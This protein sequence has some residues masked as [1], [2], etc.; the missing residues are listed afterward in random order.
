M[1]FPTVQFAVFFAVVLPLSWALMGRQRVWKPF[2]LGASYVFY[3]AVDWRFAFLLAG[4]TVVNQGAAM[5][6]VRSGGRGRKAALVGAVGADVAS[7]AVFKY[8]DFFAASVNGAVGLSLPLLHLALP[9]GVSFYTFQ[10]VSYVVDVYR[11]KTALAAPLDYAIYSAFFAHLVAGPIV[12]ATEFIPQLAGPRDAGRVPAGRAFGL[13]AGG[14]VK[15]VAIADLLGVKLVEP[16]FGAPG[17]HSGGEALAAIYGYAVQIYCDFSGYTDMAIGIALLL[18]F[19]FPANFDR[20]YTAT[21]LQDFWRRWHMTLSRWLRDYLYIALGGNRRGRLRLYRNL[22]LTML[23]GGLWHGEL[24]TFVVW[25]GLHGVGLVA[26]R[27]WRDSGL[28]A[29]AA[30][31]VER[32]PAALRRVVS[33]VVTFHVVCLAWVFFRAPDVGTAFA[34]LGRL[35]TLGDG[36]P[37]PSVTP[38]VVTVIAVGLGAQFVPRGMGPWLRGAFGRMPVAAQGVAL[39]CLV[40]V[41][42]AAAGGRGV[43]PF[44]Y[45]RF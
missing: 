23:L 17:A 25:G 37:S 16:V 21:S 26:E 40:T 32:V 15:K 45:F 44:I 36:V 38:L 7:L 31:T 12:R 27:G 30:P 34:V 11:G 28:A 39:G 2:I 1:L 41:V 29:W 24:W 13:I 19:R 10:G 9:V 35:G 3:G 43:A 20:P 4:S 22:M 5:V 8:L 18:G 33:R 6:I 14:L 42:A